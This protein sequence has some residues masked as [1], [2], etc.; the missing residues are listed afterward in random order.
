[1]IVQTARTG[2]NV[3]TCHEE[4][5]DDLASMAQSCSIT[6]V[7]NSGKNLATVTQ[8]LTQGSTVQGQTAQQTATITQGNRA[9]PNRI[10]LQQQLTQSASTGAAAVAQAQT[11]LQ[12]FSVQQ[13]GTPF[14]PFNCPN[15]TGSNDATMTQTITQTQQ[16]ASATTGAQN[17]TATLTGHLDQCS[18][19]SSTASSTQNETQDQSALGPNVSQTQQGPMNCCSFQ[20]NNPR[21][22]FG[23]SQSSSQHAVLTNGDAAPDQSEQQDAICVTSGTCTTSHSAD[24]EGSHSSNSGSGMNVHTTLACTAGICSDEPV[25]TVLT[26][27]GDTSGDYHD[28]ATLSGTLTTTDGTPLAG[29]TVSLAVGSVSCSDKTDAAG[30]AVCTV[31]LVDAPGAYTASANFAGSPPLV[32]SSGSAGF[33]ITTEETAVAY[34]GP[35]A[36][37]NGFAVQ[38]SGVLTEADSATPV[39]GRTVTFAIGSQQCSG[40]TNASG[41]ATCTIT[42]SAAL[43]PATVST[44]FAG[45]AFYDPSSDSDGVIVFAYLSAGAFAIGDGNAA[46]GTAATFWSSQWGQTNTLSGGTAPS[47]FAGFIGTL[48]PSTTTCRTTGWSTDPANSPAPPSTLPSYMAVAVSSSIGKRGNMITSPSIPKVVVVQTNPGY[49]PSPGGVGTGTVVATFCG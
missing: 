49:S 3:A 12:S 22:V 16:A 45:D 9:G 26:Y 34:S 23:I 13:S 38:L 18:N 44:S 39:S 19:S 25:P 48:L 15:M 37:P 2:Q 40:T 47:S 8:V 31:F 30:H 28:T 11:G 36:V 7:S 24:Q 32:A 29:L 17:Q 41:V 33:T 5:G 35:S 10:T 46:V 1:V 21:N 14:D 4:D 43:G 27:T 6:Q 42:P 20:Q